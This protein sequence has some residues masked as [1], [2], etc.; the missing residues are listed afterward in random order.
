MSAHRVLPSRKQ[1][2]GWSSHGQPVDQLHSVLRKRM[3][4]LDVSSCGMDDDLRQRKHFH[5][6]ELRASGQV[7]REVSDWSRII[8][9][10]LQAWQS[11][12]RKVFQSAWVVCGYVHPDAMVAAGAH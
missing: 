12:E 7:K 3:R 6:L 1:P 9:I 4:D 5:E 10:S 11:M 8:D 2:G